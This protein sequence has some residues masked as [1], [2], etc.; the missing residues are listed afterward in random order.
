MRAD[1]AR[2]TDGYSAK[3]SQQSGIEFVPV[4][5]SLLAD[6]SAKASA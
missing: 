1:V 4:T 3:A 2:L 5:Q 6:A